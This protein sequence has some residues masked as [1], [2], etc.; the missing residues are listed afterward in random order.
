MISRLIEKQ[1]VQGTGA[2]FGFNSTQCDTTDWVVLSNACDAKF[3]QYSTTDWFSNSYED[4]HEISAQHQWN[5]KTEA[6][7]KGTGESR[8][9]PGTEE[10]EMCTQT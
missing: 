5:G 2:P 7:Q 9:I 6:S 10:N 1:N 4:K 3:S 8:S